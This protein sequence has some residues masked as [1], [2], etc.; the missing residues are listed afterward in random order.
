MSKQQ[1]P[2]AFDLLKE[3]EAKEKAQ[4]ELVEPAE[5]FSSAEAT[6]DLI[7]EVRETQKLEDGK[8][9]GTIIEVD[10]RHT[11][12]EYTDITIVPDEA[13][14]LKLK[15]GVPSNL[16]TSSKLGNLLSLFVEVKAGAKLNPREVLLGRR[17]SFMTQV[18]EI[19][20]KNN[21]KMQIVKILENT[22]KSAQ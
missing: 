14:N 9:T 12:F 15:F 4:K 19:T 2:T 16:T 11:P 20:K 22:I 17:V 5:D 7:F 8:H 1:I 13:K 18:E 6:E 21:D 3:K 10:Y